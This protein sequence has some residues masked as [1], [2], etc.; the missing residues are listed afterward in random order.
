[1][2]SSPPTV[3]AASAAA[4]GTVPLISNA[5]RAALCRMLEGQLLDQ[6][7]FSLVLASASQEEPT[8]SK[9]EPPGDMMADS[10]STLPSTKML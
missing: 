10:I 1:M 8:S 5:R 4:N 9:T 6:E 7:A 2:Q 3:P